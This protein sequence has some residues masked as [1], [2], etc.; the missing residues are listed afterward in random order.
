[1]CANPERI[2]KINPEFD[3]EQGLHSILDACKKAPKQ[4]QIVMA[5]YQLYKKEAVVT[6]KNLLASTQ[7]TNAQLNI[8]EISDQNINLTA[9]FLFFSIRKNVIKNSTIKR[10][11][12]IML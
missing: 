3:T 7:T 2:V 12:Y 11:E 1:L 8:N 5:F 6:V 10:D 9:V 4:E